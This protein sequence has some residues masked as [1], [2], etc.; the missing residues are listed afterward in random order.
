MLS[1]ES[2]ESQ[3]LCCVFKG[4]V[5]SGVDENVTR[6]ALVLGKGDGVLDRDS[7]TSGE[8]LLGSV[9]LRGEAVDDEFEEL[10][11][12]EEDSLVI[13]PKCALDHFDWTL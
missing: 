2:S 11:C 3:A 10:T 7:E 8:R 4:M 12:G 9:G 5:E 13:N 6:V 1:V